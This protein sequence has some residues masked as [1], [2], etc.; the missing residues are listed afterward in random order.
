ME[1]TTEIHK[2]LKIQRL[3]GHGCIVRVATSAVKPLNRRPPGTSQKQSRKI[4]GERQRTRVSAEALPSVYSRETAHRKVNTQESYTMTTPTDSLM[5]MGNLTRPQPKMKGYRLPKA[6]QGYPRLN[7]ATQGYPWLLRQK[8]RVFSTAEHPE[9]PN[10]KRPKRM[11]IRHNVLNTR[12]QWSQ[13]LLWPG[14]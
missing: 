7:K 14:S 2:L 5:W 4:V 6:T 13:L 8:N 9:L 10:S 3:R 12:T 1:A 11:C